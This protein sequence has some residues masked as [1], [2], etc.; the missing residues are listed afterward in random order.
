MT[1]PFRCIAF[2]VLVVLQGVACASANDDDP[3]APAPSEV[4]VRAVPVAPHDAEADQVPQRA[5][6]LSPSERDEQVA[7]LAGSEPGDEALEVVDP[8]L[9]GVSLEDVLADAT[10]LLAARSLG[11]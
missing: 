3:A 5:E 1:Q 7:A 10:R 6:L 8:V 9:G 11:Q 2:T 4:D